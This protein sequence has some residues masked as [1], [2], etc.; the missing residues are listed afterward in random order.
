MGLRIV[1][2]SREYPPDTGGGIGA[3]AQR[4]VPALARRGAAVHIVTRHL[5]SDEHEVDPQSGVTIHRV[6]MGDRSGESCLRASIVVAQKLL[7]LLRG[8]GVDAIEFAEYEA[9]ASAWL[10][11]R[12]L[13]RRA[14]AVPVALHLHSPTELNATLNGHEPALLDRAM[15][16]LIEAERRC[17]ALADGV[18][19]PGSFM[20]DWAAAYFDLAGRP[21][22]IPYAAALGN[23]VE[24]T[25]SA[26]TRLYGGRLEQRKGVDTLIRA[27]NRV[28]TTFPD[29]SLRL[30]GTDTSTAPGGGSCG[31][32]LQSLLDPSLC[33][34]TEF[35][36]P[37]S[38]DDLDR[39]RSDAAIAVIPSRWENF[40]NT[41]IE[42][43]AS[44]LPVVAS[45]RGGMA[46]RRRRRRARRCAAPLD[47]H[48]SSSTHPGRTL[49][50]GSHR[51]ALRS[52]HRSGPADAVARF[53][54]RER[55]RDGS[56][57]RRACASR[58]ARSHRFPGGCAAARTRSVRSL[59]GR[60]PSIG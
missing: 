58:P 54:G 2:V 10:A 35:C 49:G 45:D 26:K 27:W 19:A 39:A 60:E 37:M 15:R 3:Y 32:W 43:M 56:G 34:R 24:Q 17:L 29:W 28:A 9:M 11:L 1:L 7:E 23:P 30:I 16:D 44:G 53:A 40:P 46:D 4:M 38:G 33:E 41:C 20:A 42:A 51:R 14:A 22:V 5:Y 31:D 25:G 59:H 52:R 57:A 36:G 21:T 13:D 48:G 8:D 50:E 12:S 6:E 47:E 18:C 55:P